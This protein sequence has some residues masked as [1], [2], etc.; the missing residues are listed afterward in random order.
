MKCSK[1]NPSN[2]FGDPTD[3]APPSISTTSCKDFFA[4][5]YK[6]AEPVI[7]GVLRRGEVMLVSGAM[8]IGT[9]FAALQLAFCASLGV[10]WLGFPT[11]TTPTLL[12]EC[13]QQPA[14]LADRARQVLS[15]LGETVPDGLRFQCCRGRAFDIGS[16]IT[17][18]DELLKGGQ[19]GLIV[20]D[21]MQ[22][23]YPAGFDEYHEVV[24]LFTKLV[25]FAESNNSAVV[26]VDRSEA[27]SPNANA[28]V[29]GGADVVATFEDAPGGKG[30]T[31][32]QFRLRATAAPEPIEAIR[33][34]G[35]WKLATVKEPVEKTRWPEVDSRL[36]G[37]SV[38]LRKRVSRSNAWFAP[39]TIPTSSNV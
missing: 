37:L 33:K 25:N 20:V 31:V 19:V 32:I 13:E 9:S 24:G 22:S 21:S 8:G 17:E 38:K 18:G 6:S 7:E 15:G 4:T 34:A 27:R 3:L 12:I 26:V 36:N 16:F 39:G 11:I 29:R 2:P 10:E 1:N 5:D 23:L 35:I 14:V 28:I 30:R